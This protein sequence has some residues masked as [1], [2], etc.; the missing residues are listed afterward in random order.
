MLAATQRSTRSLISLACAVVATNVASAQLARS[1]PETLSDKDF[2][3]FFTNMSEEGGSFPSE[4]FVSNEQTYQYVIPTLQRSLSPNGVYLGVGPEQNFTY[5]ANIKPRMAVI[6]DI[7]RQNAMAHLMYKAL[8][9]LSSTRADF[10][11]KLFSRPLPATVGPSASANELFSAALNAKMNDSA[12]DANR[13]AIFDDLVGKHGFVLTTTDSQSIKHVYA[14]FFEAGPDINYGY[15]FGAAGAF[16]PVYSTYAQI[17]TLTNV[18]GVNMAFLANEANYQYL[19]NLH[20]KNLIIPV[21]GDFAG[22][23][24]IRSVG[25]YLKQRHA[26]VTA[27]YLSNVE[28]YLFRGFEDNASKFYKNV[29]ALP[30]DSTSTFI[31]S[32]PPNNGLGG[33]F[34]ILT[35]SGMTFGSSPITNNYYS[36]QVIDSAGVSIILTTSDSAGKPVTTRTID[37][38]KTNRPSALDVFRRLRARDDSLLRLRADS[39]LHAG[40]SPGAVGGPVAGPT[41]FGSGPVSIA[42]FGGTLV[43]GL[44]SIHETLD[45]FNT[46]RLPSYSS[47]IAMTKTDKWK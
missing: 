9:E 40:G 14:S 22:P 12:F 18:D 44:A 34:G 42:G 3:E 41:S 47:V 4:N 11:S 35:S 43:S 26:T 38:S 16:R 39:A 8:F 10:V 1:L 27:F 29:D 30:I 36:V 6:F 2:W 37:T 33:V 15:R 24:A 46:G 25:D 17:Q 19:R 5:I 20:K 28:Q 32:V 45:A 31:R 13:Q 7:R 23:K 21:V